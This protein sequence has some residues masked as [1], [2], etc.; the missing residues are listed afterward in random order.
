MVPSQRVSVPFSATVPAVSAAVMRG[1]SLVPVT[2]T[3]TVVSVL[4]PSVSVAVT[5]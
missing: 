2:V 5:V 3:S 4:A 1:A